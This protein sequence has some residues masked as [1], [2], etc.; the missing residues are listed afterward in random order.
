MQGPT[1]DDYEWEL[2][3]GMSCI[4]DIC[5]KAEELPDEHWADEAWVWAKMAV[6]IV[7][8]RG[9]ILTKDEEFRCAGCAKKYGTE[10]VPK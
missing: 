2:F 6:P 3:T 7:R 1:D 9:W 5:R 10:A 4:C 8:E